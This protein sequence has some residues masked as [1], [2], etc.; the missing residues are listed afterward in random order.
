MSE[1]LQ[2]NTT[3]IIKVIE[4][5]GLNTNG[6]VTVVMT[7]CVGILLL[8]KIYSYCKNKRGE[9]VNNDV[10]KSEVVLNNLVDELKKLKE[11]TEKLNNKA[12]NKDK[13]SEKLNVVDIVESE[14]ES[15]V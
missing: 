15:K 8:M 6:V 4:S 11:E 1:D 5:T 13:K 9:T 12:K 3:E 2:I 7:A 14:I 10:K